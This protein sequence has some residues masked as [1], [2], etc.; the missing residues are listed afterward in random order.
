MILRVPSAY[1]RGSVCLMQDCSRPIMSSVYVM[2]PA[3][4]TTM[5]PFHL[6]H[7]CCLWLVTGVPELLREYAATSLS[8]LWQFIVTVDSQLCQILEFSALRLC[9]KA[10]RQ[11]RQL[12][13]L[14]GQLTKLRDKARNHFKHLILVT[15]SLP[16]CFNVCTS[17][18][19][20]P[21]SQTI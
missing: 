10:V 21:L 7:T 8:L 17:V 13:V 6:D 20:R 12:F 4:L 9:R 11:Y 2:P 16:V 15:P 5:R 14:S 19:Q 18:G 1:H 3:C